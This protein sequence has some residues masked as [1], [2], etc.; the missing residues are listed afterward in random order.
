MCDW[1]NHFLLRHKPV[2]DA[3]KVVLIE[4]QPPRGF[5]CTEQLLYA[6][7]RHKARLVAPASIHSFFHTASLSYD[8][9]KR[10]MVAI[11]KQRFADSKVATQALASQRSHDIADAMLMGVYFASSE[12]ARE[13]FSRSL[14]VSRHTERLFDQYR[15]NSLHTLPRARNT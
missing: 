6:A 11:A 5:R 12:Y 3:A 4:R 10:R 13:W 7:M 2:F 8:D 9:R 1:V 15:Y 14:P